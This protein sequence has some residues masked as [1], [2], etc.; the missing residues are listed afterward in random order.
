DATDSPRLSINNKKTIYS[1]KAGGSAIVT[2]LR[3]CHDNHI[4]VTRQYKDKIR[5]MLSLHEK[6]KLP[7]NEIASL[8]GHLS[9]VRTVAPTFFSKICA[10]F[11]TTIGQVL[12]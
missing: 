10:R 4:T 5:L 8:R 11:V 1:S 12:K 6:Q 3:I 9:Y 7:A 2:G